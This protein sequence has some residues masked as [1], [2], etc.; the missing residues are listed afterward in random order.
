MKKLKPLTFTDFANIVRTTEFATPKWNDQLV[1]RAKFSA[2]TYASVELS[3]QRF[4]S[5]APED[6]TLKIIGWNPHQRSKV[7]NHAGSFCSMYIV[8]GSL[9]HTRFRSSE[10]GLAVVEESVVLSAGSH[11]ILNREA[12]HLLE[13]DSEEKAISRHLY[14]PRLDMSNADLYE[15]A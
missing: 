15:V 14:C 4:Y 13:N 2:A 1:T 6:F 3:P 9:R 12:I 7:H 8:Q 10:Q 5:L 11:A